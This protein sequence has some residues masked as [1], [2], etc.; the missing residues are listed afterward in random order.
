MS[1]QPRRI[2]SALLAGSLLAA[3]EARDPGVI[4]PTTPSTPAPTLA[5]PPA[6]A[7][8]SASATASAGAAA[9]RPPPYPVTCVKDPSFPTPWN[10]PEASAAAEVELRP[11]A[12]EILV[13][14]DSGRKGAAMA[15]SKAGGIRAIT[16][17]LDDAAS[18]DLE[19][20]SWVPGSP[21]RFYTLTSSGAVRVFVPDGNGGLL[22]EGESYRI[23]PPPLSC[24]DLHGINCNKNWEGLCLRS[25]SARARCVG[26]AASKAETALY[27]V[28]KDTTGR[29]SIDPQGPVLRPALEHWVAGHGVLSDCAFGAPGGP[30]QD[31]LLVTTNLNGGSRTYV[32]DEASGRAAVVDVPSTPNNEAVA[33]DHEGALYLFLDDNGLTSGALRFTCDAWKG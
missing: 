29:I 21:S 22:R 32:V 26:W 19:A 10:V 13:V 30:A 3:C 31:V 5:P 8:A 4:W 9:S 12:R 28:V 2:A 1:A 6:S 23:A 17:P 24:D 27:C 7:P 25:P 14:S 15:W 11:G 18:D 20:A 33:V 16:L